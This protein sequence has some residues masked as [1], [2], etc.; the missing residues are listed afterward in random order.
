[1]PRRPVTLMLA[2]RLFTLMD[3]LAGVRVPRHFR[4]SIVAPVFDLKPLH[5]LVIPSRPIRLRKQRHPRLLTG[6][7]APLLLAFALTHLL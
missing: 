3:N 2:Q 1:V 7:T 4:V 5:P 6:L